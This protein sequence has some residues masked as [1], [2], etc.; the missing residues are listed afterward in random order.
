MEYHS[1]KHGKGRTLEQYTIAAIDF[2]N[3]N[4]GLGK[5]IQL[6]DG[7]FGIKI[8]TKRVINGKVVRIGGFWTESGKVVTF[9]D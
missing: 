9:W 1:Q 5:N 2:Y 4:K 7:T 3:K 8:Q 6:K